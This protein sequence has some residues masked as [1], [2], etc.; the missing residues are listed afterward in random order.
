MRNEQCCDKVGVEEQKKGFRI[1][2]LVFTC[3]I[4]LLVLVNLTFSPEFI[5][6]IFPLFG[7]GM[8][9]AIHYINVRTLLKI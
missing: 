3:V 6:S 7:W 4:T 1:H 8:G 5:W 2:R 9:L